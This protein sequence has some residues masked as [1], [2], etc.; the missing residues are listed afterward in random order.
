[1]D[2]RTQTTV[3]GITTQNGKVT[4]VDTPPDHLSAKYV[5]LA[6]GAWTHPLG[7]T[8]GVDI[9]A[10]WVHGEAIITEPIP[11]S[12][13]N[14]MSSASFFEEAASSERDRGCLG[15]EAARRG[16]CHVR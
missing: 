9:P 5:V 14:A 12:M 13:A 15:F 7:L 10:S 3:T 6:T 11:P 1:M 4:G 8:A 16:Q 2:V